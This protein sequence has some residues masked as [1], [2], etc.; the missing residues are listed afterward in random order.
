MTFDP[1]MSAM[2]RCPKCATEKPLEDFYPDRRAADGRQGWCKKCQNA[3]SSVKKPSEPRLVRNRARHRAIAELVRRHEAEFESLYE[4]YKAEAAQEA[5]ELRVAPAAAQHY[6]TQPVR[7]RP[8][9]RQPGERATDRID[10][11]RCPHCIKHHDSGHV[12]P[13]CGAVPHTVVIVPDDGH[14]DE[15]AVERAMAGDAVGITQ[16]EQAEAFRRLAG[17]GLSDEVIAQRL[18]V[19]ARTV[20]RWRQA[21]GLESRWTA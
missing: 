7:L 20:L 13:K 6:K 17:K 4:L 9:A 14:V 21:Q 3:A 12:C 5:V 10:V 16:R 11:A 8:G 19:H 1:Q 2:K 15:I 18:G